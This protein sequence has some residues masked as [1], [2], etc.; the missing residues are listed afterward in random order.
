MYICCGCYGLEGAVY[1]KVTDV[2]VPSKRKHE[3][4]DM[5]DQWGPSNLTLS[6]LS[7]LGAVNGTLPG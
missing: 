3:L 1:G 5:R 7:S 6:T 2:L 4:M